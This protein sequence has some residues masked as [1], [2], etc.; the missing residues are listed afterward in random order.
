MFDVYVQL[1]MVHGAIRHT[2]IL[3]ADSHKNH[4]TK[5]KKKQ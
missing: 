3:F 2:T 5:F 1:Y 4:A